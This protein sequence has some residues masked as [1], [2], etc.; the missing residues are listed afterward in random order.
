MLPPSM[1]SFLKKFKPANDGAKYALMTTY[2]DPRV[3]ALASMEKI[4]QKKGMV[5]ITDGFKVKAL[6][7]EGPLEEG[8]LGRLKEFSDQLIA[9]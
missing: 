5:K 2:L 7:I 1:K 8:Y 9:S 3:K 4:L 6:N